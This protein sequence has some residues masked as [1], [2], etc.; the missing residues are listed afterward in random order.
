MILN[1]RAMDTYRGGLRVG[2]APPLGVL[3]QM[4]RY[5]SMGVAPNVLAGGLRN[6]Q[7]AFINGRMNPLAL[8]A[9]QQLGG[10]R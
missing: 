9:L 1:P 4:G 6:Q 8:F 7:A 10:F 5:R 2:A 3:A